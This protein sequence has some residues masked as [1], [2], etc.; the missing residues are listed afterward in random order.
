[1]TSSLTYLQFEL[2]RTLRNR[3]FVLLS[4][5]FPVVL[6]LL[7]ASG[8]DAAN[9]GGSGIPARLYY[10]VGMASFGAM[11]AML[12]GGARIAAERAVGWNRQLRLTPMS[13]R[14]Y[15]RSKILASYALALATLALLAIAGA[16]LGVWLPAQAWLS[17]GGLWI[18][19]LVPFA[20]FGVWLGHVIGV[21]AIGPATGATT[22]LLAFVSGSWY[23]L[24][25]GTLATV[26]TYLPSYWLV[27]ASRCAL[28][29]QAWP[30]QA[31]LV[32]GAWSA[33]L[34]LAAARAYRRTT[35]RA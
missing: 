2:V 32:I 24:G 16:A 33:V 11:S 8:N 1:M 27:Q 29:G 18:V 31:W 6:F 7:M 23:P 3:R 30:M 26:A 19:G 12:G 28:T 35:Q 25:H 17:L 20:A 5:G 9:L 21:D 14:V 15:L 13:A 4:I 34:G 22:A 10:L